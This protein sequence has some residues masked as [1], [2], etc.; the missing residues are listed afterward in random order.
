MRVNEDGTADI[1]AEETLGGSTE[2]HP[3][4]ENPTLT[5]A[6]QTRDWFSQDKDFVV[7]DVGCY[8]G[9]DGAAYLDDVGRDRCRVF[10]FE[11]DPKIAYWYKKDHKA[12]IEDG[13]MTLIESAV[14]NV[15]GE[16]TWY[17]SR[18]I[19]TNENAPSGTI[20]FPRGHMNHHKHIGFKETKVPSLKLDT[21][22]EQQDDVDMIDFIHV[23]VNGGEKEFLEGALT[24]LKEHTKFLWMEFMTQLGH[25]DD[26]HPGF[27]LIQEDFTLV[28]IVGYNQ[29]WVNNKLD[30]KHAFMKI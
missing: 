16:L 17:Q 12:L 2:S 21:W 19:E 24:T 11:A 4:E 20:K 7:L 23:D 18:I 6:I 25:W 29:L 9:L 3:L 14:S 13:H 15:D 5:E 8:N 30:G 28:G 1:F 22:F 27:E 10:S 26:A